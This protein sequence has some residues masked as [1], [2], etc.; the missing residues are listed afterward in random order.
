MNMV[1]FP[2]QTRSDIS[3]PGSCTDV[4][5]TNKELATEAGKGKTNTKV[6]ALGKAIAWLLPNFKTGMKIAQRLIIARFKNE[7]TIA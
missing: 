6:A 5:K 4:I 2:R 1:I 3:T 7:M